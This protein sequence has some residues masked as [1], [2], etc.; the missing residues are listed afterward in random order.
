MHVPARPGLG[1]SLS[2]EARALTVETTRVGE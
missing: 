2:D 1:F